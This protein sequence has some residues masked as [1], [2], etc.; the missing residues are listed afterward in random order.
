[1]GEP[2]DKLLQVA[3]GDGLEGFVVDAGEEELEVPAVCGLGVG[4]FAM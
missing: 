4:A 3:E 1:M 2:L